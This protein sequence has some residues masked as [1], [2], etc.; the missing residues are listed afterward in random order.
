MDLRSLACASRDMVTDAHWRHAAECF[1]PGA[2]TVLFGRPAFQVRALLAKPSA[3]DDPLRWTDQEHLST[4]DTR[5]C[6]LL[7]LRHNGFLLWRGTST[8]E[9]HNVP[10]H[11]FRGRGPTSDTEERISFD[12]PVEVGEL[13]EKRVVSWWQQAGTDWPPN[14]FGA[15]QEFQCLHDIFDFAKDLTLWFQVWYATDGK[16]HVLQPSLKL[17]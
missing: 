9:M 5:N 10:T 4:R 12:L 6:V 2:T 14:M 3:I 11:K 8:I 15:Q 1:W 13:L 16:P 17:E 7:E